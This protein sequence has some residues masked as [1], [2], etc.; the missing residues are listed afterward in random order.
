MLVKM[1]CFVVILQTLFNG[2][3]ACDTNLKACI[4]NILDNAG[5]GLTYGYPFYNYFSKNPDWRDD[6]NNMRSDTCDIPG[7]PYHNKNMSEFDVSEITDFSSCFSTSGHLSHNFIIHFDLNKWDVSKGTN[8][9]RMFYGVDQ[10][11]ILGTYSYYSEFDNMILSDWNVSSGIN[12]DQMFADGY[13]QKLDLKNW[14][15]LN[16]A[17]VT[18]MLPKHRSTL[19]KKDLTEWFAGDLVTQSRVFANSNVIL[20]DNGEQNS[21]TGFFYPKDSTFYDYTRSCNFFCANSA[22][23][24]LLSNFACPYPKLRTS[25]L[26][27]Y[28]D[29]GEREQK[30]CYNPCDDFPADTT[31]RLNGTRIEYKVGDDCHY[32]DASVIKAADEM[33]KNDDLT[34][35]D[36][37]NVIL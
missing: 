6:I 34:L 16:S 33:L 24:L 27:Y 17:S 37:C 32:A 26:L 19:L 23:N 12:F 18:R 11:N 28:G 5:N 3:S 35:D 15:I 22:L 25:A 2:C 31:S 9:K 29:A 4:D 13:F 10:S 7:N 36:N 1:L 8:F 21:C 14:Q 30:C 20:S